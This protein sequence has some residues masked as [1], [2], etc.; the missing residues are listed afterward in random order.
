[1]DVSGEIATMTVTD[2][3]GV[4][5]QIVLAFLIGMYCL[6]AGVAV[7]LAT[8]GIAALVSSHGL[9]LS[10][11]L[12]VGVMLVIVAGVAAIRILFHS[13]ILRVENR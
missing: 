7:L 11:Q 5:P 12:G 6:V 8:V 9:R 2:R 10:L 1:M 4:H 3:V 13:G